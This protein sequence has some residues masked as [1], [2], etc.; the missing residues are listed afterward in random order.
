[1]TDHPSV[2]SRRLLQ[3]CYRKI[4]GQSD[5]ILG[6]AVVVSLRALLI[7]TMIS[8]NGKNGQL[9]ISKIDITTAQKKTE[10]TK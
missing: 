4:V 8:E 5:P 1:M 2:N 6:P 3:H 10:I 9:N 7:W